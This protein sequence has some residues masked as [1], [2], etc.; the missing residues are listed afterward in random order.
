MFGVK[1]RQLYR[2]T[3][4]TEKCKKFKVQKVRAESKFQ[5]KNNDENHQQKLVSTNVRQ[6]I[7]HRQRNHFDANRTSI[8]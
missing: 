4:R 7:L 6:K 1:F 3:L 8:T 2:F 5:G